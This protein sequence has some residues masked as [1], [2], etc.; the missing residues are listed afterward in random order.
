MTKE[1]NN[2]SIADFENISIDSLKSRGLK[3]DVI[4]AL[5]N[6]GIITIGNLKGKE[7]KEL[8]N[9]R[10]VD[11]LEEIVY[12]IGLEHNLDAKH[13]MEY[14]F[15]SNENE[16][17]AKICKNP[18]DVP[19]Y[20]LDC[21]GSVASALYYRR[22]PSIYTIEDL[23]GMKREVILG[24]HGIGPK[25]ADKLC[26]ALQMHGITVVGGKFALESRRRDEKS[27]DPMSNAI[28]VHGGEK[29]GDTSD[30]IVQQQLKEL[31][32]LTGEVAMLNTK[33]IGKAIDALKQIIT[34]EKGR[35]DGING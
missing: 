21:P 20:R 17:I 23:I 16:T 6:Q 33:A 28:I 5:K 12:I 11:E 29:V 2:L 27:I 14:P 10:Y 35:G 30:K 1:E 34:E 24:T 18:L 26:K 25:K 19:I 22:E 3:T 8:P 9:V 31:F 7:S 13:F 15:V 4:K 32:V